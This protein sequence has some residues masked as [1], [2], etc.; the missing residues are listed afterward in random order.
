VFPADDIGA[1]NNLA[2]WRKIKRNLDYSS[3]K[4]ILAQWHPYS[5]MIYFHL[6]LDSLKSIDSEAQRSG[7]GNQAPAA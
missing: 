7:T 6:L 1:R 3:V 4:R 5:G 2:R